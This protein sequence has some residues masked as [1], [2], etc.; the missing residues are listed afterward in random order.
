M[1]KIIDFSRRSWKLYINKWSGGVFEDGNINFDISDTSL[2]YDNIWKF[3]TPLET[4]KQLIF[5]GVDQDT[6]LFVYA[7]RVKKNNFANNFEN[8]I[9]VT[10]IDEF[11]N[12]NSTTVKQNFIHVGYASDKN[13][14]CDDDLKLSRNSILLSCE[15]QINNEIKAPVI[16]ED[17]IK[18]GLKDDWWKLDNEDQ[19][20]FN[21]HIRNNIVR[22]FGSATE[23]KAVTRYSL[24]SAKHR[25]I[26]NKNDY[27]S[28]NKKNFNSINNSHAEDWLGNNNINDYFKYFFRIGK[29]NNLRSI[30]FSDEIINFI[31]NERWN[32]QSFTKH[33]AKLKEIIEFCNV[34]LIKMAKNAFDSTEKRVLLGYKIYKLQ[35]DAE[36]M[37]NVRS[38][39]LTKHQDFYFKTEQQ[40]LNAYLGHSGTIDDGY[41]EPIKLADKHYVE[42]GRKVFND[43]YSQDSSYKGIEKIGVS[44]K[45][46]SEHFDI[47]KL[48]INKFN[49]VIKKGIKT[50][51]LNPIEQEIALNRY[52]G[53]V[54]LPKNVFD[55][56]SKHYYGYLGIDIKSGKHIYYVKDIVN[57]NIDLLE[58]NDLLT[59]HDPKNKL[60]NFG[61]ANN[62]D[63]LP[64]TKDLSIDLLKLQKDQSLDISSFPEKVTNKIRNF[65]KINNLNTSD[66]R[67]STR[68]KSGNYIYL[69]IENTSVNFTDTHP[70][71]SFLSH[72]WKIIFDEDSMAKTVK[73]NLNVDFFVSCNRSANEF[74]Y[75]H[76]QA[77]ANFASFGEVLLYIGTDESTKLQLYV[78]VFTRQ[79]YIFDKSTYTPF[80]FATNTFDGF[81]VAKNQ[82]IGGRDIES[83]DDLVLQKIVRT[84]NYGLNNDLD[85]V[86][87][88]Q[89]PPIIPHNNAV[90]ISTSNLLKI[91]YNH[92]F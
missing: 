74:F 31:K 70:Y 29:E 15:K 85:L 41:I 48:K 51:E 28:I 43:I 75:F 57:R 7:V 40:P 26:T 8:L 17:K 62:F 87:R 91:D 27:F 84:R 36:A 39:S 37:A 69:N 20:M 67:F 63:Q 44:N 92:Q 53:M 58:S 45:N 61:F 32:Y 68:I 46:V 81:D 66:F 55:S 33:A 16:F 4:K 60:V 5:I 90:S 42:D 82:S 2:I 11:E 73:L 13:L 12:Q 71:N 72:T 49:Y 80:G 22:P 56:Y 3:Y 54:Y 47:I 52:S 18:T 77:Y 50:I 23:P 21:N 65:Q 10:N 76:M 38:G 59:V 88:A 9:F 79:I 89:N 35:I 86:V 78:S 1:H 14:L 30:E 34:G 24:K 25:I 19:F 6:S 83:F 64:D